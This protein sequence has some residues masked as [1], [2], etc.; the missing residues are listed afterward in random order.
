MGWG[1]TV[2]FLLNG[3]LLEAAGAPSLDAS[4]ALL[5]PMF[6][7]AFGQLYVGWRYR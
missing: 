1:A 3:E 4:D 6:G 5:V 7:W 2:V